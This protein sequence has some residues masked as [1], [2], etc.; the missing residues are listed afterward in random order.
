MTAYTLK[1]SLKLLFGINNILSLGWDNSRTNLAKKKKKKCR[2]P[3]I[4]TKI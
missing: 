3:W 4:Y 1:I 2:W